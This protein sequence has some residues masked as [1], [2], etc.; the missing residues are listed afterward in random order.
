MQVTHDQQWWV[1]E[2][3]QTLSRVARERA[4]SFKPQT[5]SRNGRI[6][7]LLC[8]G[9]FLTSPNTVAYWGP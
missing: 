5:F 8:F 9:S 4:D 7:S 1:V 3:P 6:A 2:V